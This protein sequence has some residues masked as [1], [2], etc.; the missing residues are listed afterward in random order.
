MSEWN[1]AEETVLAAGLCT[2]LVIQSLQLACHWSLFRLLC[3]QVMM[4]L[5]QQPP[6]PL[7]RN[8]SNSFLGFSLTKHFAIFPPLHAK[9]MALVDPA[10]EGVLP[11]SKG[12]V[13]GCDHC[14]GIAV[15]QQDGLGWGEKLG[16]SRWRPVLFAALHWHQRFSSTASEGGK[17]PDGNGHVPDLLPPRSGLSEWRW[18]REVPGRKDSWETSLSCLISLACS[19]QP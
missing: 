9:Q 12:G 2:I 11:G 1:R 19:A 7:P 13:V 5:R 6:D 18:R 17:M 3:F 8:L 4:H 14:H 15:T 10:W 16:M